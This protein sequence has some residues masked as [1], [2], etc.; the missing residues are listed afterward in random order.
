MEQAHANVSKNISQTHIVFGAAG[1]LG[2]AIV[3]RLAALG[4]PARAVVR[5]L[6]RAKQML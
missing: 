2:A 4:V 5:S 6:D 1:S 3:R